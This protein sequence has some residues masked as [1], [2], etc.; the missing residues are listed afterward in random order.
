MAKEIINKIKRQPTEWKNI[1]T[2][3]FDK[4]LIP[5]IYKEL[6]LISI[7]TDYK[8]NR[9]VFSVPGWECLCDCEA[10]Y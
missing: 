6:A 4:G 8:I 5:K 10:W 9:P 7:G 1:F 3:T 2:D